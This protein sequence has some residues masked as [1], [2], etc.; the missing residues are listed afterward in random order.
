ML[1]TMQQVG[2]VTD[3]KLDTSKNGDA[4]LGN[5]SYVRHKRPGLEEELGLLGH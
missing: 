1:E 4:R 2:R 3:I 5:C